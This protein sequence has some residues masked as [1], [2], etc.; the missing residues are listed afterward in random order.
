MR[1]NILAVIFLGTFFIVGCKS[2]ELTPKEESKTA[3][4]KEVKV[5]PNCVPIIL[6]KELYN[7]VQNGGV[8]VLE[9]KIEGNY[10]YLKYSFSG[11]PSDEIVLVWN[12]MLLKSY[13]G[14][15]MLKLGYEETGSCDEMRTQEACYDLKD[16]IQY[17]KV[18]LNVNGS[19][20]VLFD[21]ES[22]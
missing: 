2:T 14:K 3:V 1:A 16:F 17:K 8:Q 9:S 20:A 5:D 19:S 13:P 12:N 15:A 4:K 22:E 7:K 21:V 11:C 6:E 18:H 10:L